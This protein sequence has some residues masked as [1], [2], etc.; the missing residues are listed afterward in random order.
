MRSD[1]LDLV[2]QAD[3]GLAAAEADEEMQGWKVGSAVVSV[4]S[5]TLGGAVGGGGLVGAALGFL[6]GIGSVIIELADGGES[7][8]DVM[9]RLADGLE[10]LRSLY[11]EQLAGLEQGLRN[12]LDELLNKPH[13]PDV[14]PEPPTIATRA[15]LDP[16]EFNLG[17]AQD[18]EINE[19]VDTGPL[20]PDDGTGKAG[21]GVGKGR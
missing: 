12:I 6:S 21:A 1:L 8:I 20:V 11:E 5:S 4:L 19:K 9:Q 16:R 14:N 10:G 18:E 2:Q 13:L 7:E 17:P 15:N 3:E